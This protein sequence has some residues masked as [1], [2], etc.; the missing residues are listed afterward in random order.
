MAK[1]V[2]FLGLIVAASGLVS[3]PIALACGLI[4]GFTF[5]HPYHVDSRKLSR[6]LW[7]RFS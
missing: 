1:N 2:F 4:Y 7:P 3:P 5:V 6:F